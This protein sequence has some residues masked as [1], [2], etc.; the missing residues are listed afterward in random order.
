MTPTIAQRLSAQARRWLK[1]SRTPVLVLLLALASSVALWAGK[2]IYDTRAAN[3]TIAALEKNEDVA[4][5]P[6]AAHGEVLIARMTFVLKQGLRDEAQ[7]LADMSKT[8]SATPQQ[9][10]RLLTLLANSRIRTALTFIEA[11]RHDE[12]IPEVRL[13]KD[14]YREALRLDPT[15][16]DAKHNFDVAMR[17]VR[18]LPEGEAENEEVPPDAP[19]HLWTDLP[20]VPRGLP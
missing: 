15:A 10:A 19:K 9:R 8:G 14:G 5:D 16:W 12:A 2:R 13:A 20:G 7:A 11:G 6:R 3:R 17:L 4:I 1:E 18:D